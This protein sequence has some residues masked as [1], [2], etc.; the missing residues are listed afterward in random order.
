[1]RTDRPRWTPRWA[2]RLAWTALAILGGG[3]AWFGFLIFG[4]TTSHA[5]LATTQDW[6]VN[7]SIFAGTSLLFAGALWRAV[8]AWRGR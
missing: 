6:I 3:A 4:L 2:P 7:T 1:M 8:R 5:G